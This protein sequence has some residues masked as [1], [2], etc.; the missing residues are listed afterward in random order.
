MARQSVLSAPANTLELPNDELLDFVRGGASGAEV[1]AR[2]ELLF[3][4]EDVDVVDLFSDE[5]PSVEV[6][7][8]A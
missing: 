4:S 3:P 1:L 6:P 5:V 8:A 2:L 7:S